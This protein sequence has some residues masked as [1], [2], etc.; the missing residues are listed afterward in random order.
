MIIEEATSEQ[1]DISTCLEILKDNLQEM[2][3]Q[4]IGWDTEFKRTELSQPQMHYYIVKDNTN[5][6]CAFCS[7]TEEYGTEVEDAWIVY[8]Y[9]LQVRK[10]AQGKGLG[11]M[12]MEKL[13]ARARTLQAKKVML[14]CFCMNKIALNFYTHRGYKTDETS[15]EGNVPYRILSLKIK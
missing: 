12:L 2:Y 7:Y 15:P 3:E 8:C 14:T 13:E 1:I 4:T 10:D 6:I 11:G 9:E 5:R